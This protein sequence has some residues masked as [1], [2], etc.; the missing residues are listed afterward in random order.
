MLINKVIRLVLIIN[1]NSQTM[2]RLIGQVLIINDLVGVII[3]RC[4]LCE[5]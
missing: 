2:I 5:F 3:L 4:G 1:D